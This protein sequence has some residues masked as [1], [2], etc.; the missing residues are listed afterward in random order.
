MRSVMKNLRNK[1]R[2]ITSNTQKRLYALSANVCANPICRKKLV[3]DF[4]NQNGEIAHICAASPDGP[5]YDASM[6]DDERRNIDNLILLCGDCNKLVDNKENVEKYPV[7]LLKDWKKNHEG[8]V[9]SD[10][11]NVFW[12]NIFK[13]QKE[14]LLKKQNL[15]FEG[16]DYSSKIKVYSEKNFVDELSGCRCLSSFLL[17]LAKKYEWCNFPDVFVK[18]IGGIGKSTEIKHAYNLYLEVFSDQKNYDDFQFFPIPYFFE[19][20]EY[21]RDFFKN[22]DRNENII[23]F[24]DG[25]D[26]ISYKEY[27]DFVKYLKNLKSQYSNLR[28]II[29]GRS[30]SFTSEIENVFINALNID[31]F[32]DFDLNDE[33]NKKLVNRYKNSKILDFL[34][35]PFYRSLLEQGLEVEG[36]RDFYEKAVLKLLNNDKK[37]A[38]YAENIRERDS[39][40]SSIDINRIVKKLSVFCHN[41]FFEN[42]IVFSEKSLKEYLGNDFHFVIH[43]SL[44]SYRDE[45]FISFV[46]NLYFEY[47]LALY[48]KIA[49]KNRICNELFLKSKRVKVSS[50]N[51]IGM[52]LNLLDEKD[53]LYDFLSKRLGKESKAFVLQTDF[54]LLESRKRFNYY[55][56]IFEEY[57]DKGKFIY[58][59]TFDKK[60]NCLFGISSLNVSLYNLLPENCKD[61]CLVYLINCLDRYDLKKNDVNAVTFINAIVLLGV[62]NHKIWNESQ[63]KLLKE[64]SI[65]ITK[66]FIYDAYLKKRSKGFL[67]ESVFLDWYKTYGW[68]KTWSKNEWDNFLLEI[69]PKTSGFGFYNDDNDFFIQLEIFNIFIDDSYIRSFAKCLCTEILK[70]IWNDVTGAD[71]I[72]G[73]ID[74]DYHLPVVHHDYRISNFCY[75]IE[76]INLLSVNDIV[77]I[78]CN[79][80]K[81][82]VQLNSS[83][84]EFNRIIK[85]FSQ[86]WL[87]NAQNLST[88]TAEPI[89][90]LLLIMMNDD[91]E[92]VIYDFE[93]YLDVLPDGVKLDILER[94]EENFKQQGDWCK[95]RWLDFIITPLLNSKAF[96][97]KMH[98]QKFGHDNYKSLVCRIYKSCGESHV[99]Y[100]SVKYVYQD[101]FEESIRKEENLS[102]E[103]KQLDCEYQKMVDKEPSLIIDKSKILSEI[104]RIENFYNQ[105]LGINEDEKYLYEIYNLPYEHVK[106]NVQ[107]N[108][109]GNYKKVPVFSEFTLRYLLIFYRSK[110]RSTFFATAKE[111]L[112]EWFAKESNFWRFFYHFFICEYPIE[113]SEDFLKKNETV[114]LKI[115]ESLKLEV[116]E[117]LYK[118]N[119]DG[120]DGGK[121]NAWIIPF[122]KYLPI[123]FKNEIPP[124]VDKEKLLYFML[125]PSMYLEK[126]SIHDSSFKWEECDN[127]F[128]WLN[129]KTGKSFEYLARK[130]I[131]FYPYLK[132]KKSKAQILYYLVNNRKS[133]KD[134]E[135]KIIDFVEIETLKELDADYSNG[136]FNE[137]NYGVLSEFWK[138]AE[139]SFVAKI[140]EM[141]PFERYGKADNNSCL[142]EIFETSIRLM[143]KQQKNIL[144]KKFKGSEDKNIRELLLK[145]GYEKEILRT[146]QECLNGKK[147]SSYMERA[148]SNLFGF[149]E[150]NLRVLLAYW[151][152]FKYSLDKDCARRN[153]LYSIAKNGIKEH[154]GK[155][156]FSFLKFGIMHLVKKRRRLGLYCEGLLDF[157]DEIEQHVF[158]K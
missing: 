71:S 111:Q 146:I 37:R 141:I 12:N 56:E 49:G 122:I 15:Y 69:V 108:W 20:K 119:L 84:Y 98:L 64:K 10:I 88:S 102:N 112:E 151:K 45:K 140:F 52:L 114:R 61:D 129:Q 82:K 128:V 43:S 6:T 91:S 35:I 7:S 109:S 21:Q 4:G 1:A 142:Y 125:F 60:Y 104:N 73:E 70:R 76:N 2:E 28:F 89:Y 29:S 115:C 106:H 65:K 59:L 144:I 34:H 86:I 41:L 99:L 5:R 134:L 105:D 131:D 17:T 126:G 77:E 80:K 53:K 75:Y 38:D 135:N 155:Y 118:I 83:N 79:L 123:L 39:E 40:E 42:R 97:A 8:F 18:G 116:T 117:F 156:S 74:D 26:E 130:A 81:S 154:L 103:L 27:L 92:I 107:Y 3:D 101:L 66:S 127:V 147:M 113:I 93:K 13:K 57:N 143:T 138:N 46:S 44:I 47:F 54:H 100:H 33:K 63:Q 32:D 24:L 72:P 132:D 78:I 30:A 48:Y 137:I 90:N 148:R 139:F 16:S 158:A 85:R 153:A 62:W 22:Y 23:L 95:Y 36:C 67:S 124:F 149:M 157:I 110:N 58:Y 25:L 121:R 14:G 50:I 150:P 94:I 87:S 152:L 120:M 51:V 145:I 31:L 19:L 136:N 133:F 9:S 68:T 11:Y 96:D 55:K